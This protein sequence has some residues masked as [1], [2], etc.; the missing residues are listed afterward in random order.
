MV[1]HLVTSQRPGIY[2]SRIILRQRAGVFAVISALAFM[3]GLLLF[4]IA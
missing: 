3:L 1:Y 4:T 2:P